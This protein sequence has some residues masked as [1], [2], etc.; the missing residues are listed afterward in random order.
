MTGKYYITVHTYAGHTS[1]KSLNDGS[2]D[3]IVF[4]G[5]YIPL[6]INGFFVRTVDLQY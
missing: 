5:L 4:S 6:Y 2:H 1:L 3:V